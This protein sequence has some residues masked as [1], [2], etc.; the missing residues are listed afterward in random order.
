MLVLYRA[1]NLYS[2]V[3]KKIY[4]QCTKSNKFYSIF[5][6]ALLVAY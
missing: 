4:F 1:S 5:M 3:V 2:N 6:L